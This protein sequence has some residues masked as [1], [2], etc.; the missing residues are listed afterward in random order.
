MTCL[1]YS[2]KQLYDEHGIQM[3]EEIVFGVSANL[4]FRLKTNV[5]Y[6][7]IGYFSSLATIE[8]EYPKFGRYDDV[9]SDAA[10]LNKL[11][12]E[13]TD[14]QSGAVFSDL[15][16]LESIRSTNELFEATSDLKQIVKG[17]EPDIKWDIIASNIGT[18]LINSKEQNPSRPFQ[19]KEI[20]FSDT[21][22]SNPPI[23]TSFL[24]HLTFWHGQLMFMISSN[25]SGIDSVHVDRLVELF[26]KT[27]LKF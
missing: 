4:R 5:D 17:L 8:T 11:I 1:F 27:L 20:Y 25:K 6:S 9:W 10:Y 26:E 18:Y 15:Y 21:L 13:Y 19:I 2:L 16:G 23:D 7:S 12:C 14:T 22:N 3:P 24:V